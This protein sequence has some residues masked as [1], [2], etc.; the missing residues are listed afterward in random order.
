MDYLVS[1]IVPV[2][3][4]EKYI[5]RCV[6]SILEQSYTN[7]ELILV[8]DG[9]PD[10]SG[11]ICDSYQAK[12]QRVKVIHKENGGPSSARNEG[13]KISTGNY[14]M[15]VDSD[16]FIS[17]ECLSKLVSI[18]NTYGSDLVIANYTVY[19]GE[20]AKSQ[21]EPYSK[22]VRL[23]KKD[24]F[25][26]LFEY[27]KPIFTAWAKLYK[28]S[29]IKGKFFNEELHF[30]EDMEFFLNIVEDS[31]AIVFCD[32]AM[33]FYSQEGESL[34]RTRFNRNYFLR[35]HII[36]KWVH[37][38]CRSFPQLKNKAYGYYVTELINTC[39]QIKNNKEYKEELNYYLDVL[40]K[41][42]WKVLFNSYV[43]FKDKVKYILLF[44]G[45]K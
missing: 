23:S 22:I 21:I 29:L 6:D 20:A 12:D 13:L 42:R 4:V 39:R 27:K 26:R 17:K 35:I 10:N 5:K 40:K 28:A 44:R 30:A 31:K 8:D 37:V 9:T 2:Y 11:A 15:F 25:S 34:C 1:I 24:V 38:S 16:D 7:F 18:A 32:R 33:Y 43:K 45:E 3:K 14:I 36:E 19:R 41:H